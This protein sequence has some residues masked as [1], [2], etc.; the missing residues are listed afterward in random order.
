MEQGQ[1][2]L[3]KEEAEFCRVLLKTRALK[4]G[5]FKLTSGKLSPYYVDLRSIPSYPEEFRKTIEVYERLARKA[6]GLDKFD[7][8]SCVPTSG[9]LFASVLAFNLSKPILYARKEKRTHGRERRIE[10]VMAPGDRVIIVDDLI[11]TGKSLADA[12]EALRA[13][14]GLVTDALALVDREEGGREHLQEIG[15][16]LHA[17]MRVSEIADRLYKLGVIEEGKYEEILRQ[18]SQ[19]ERL[20]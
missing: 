16:R 9:L 12:T 11:T 2:E 4:F 15:V 19:K 13:E 14:G 17:F 8:I 5:T 6:V 18:S 7:R 20:N 3:D 10:G 1:S